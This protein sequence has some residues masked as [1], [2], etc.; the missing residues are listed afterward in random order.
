MKDIESIEPDLVHLWL[1][2]PGRNGCIQL[3]LDTVYSSEKILPFADWIEKFQNT[4]GH[5]TT[6]WDGLIV[7]TGD[8]NIGQESLQK[9]MEHFSTF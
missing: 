3:L 7:V 4:L 9:V 1:E 2:V 5:L 8:M 6:T